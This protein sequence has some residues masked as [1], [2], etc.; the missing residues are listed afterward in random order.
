MCQ[1]AGKFTRHLATYAFAIA[2]RSAGRKP[3]EHTP[4]RQADFDSIASKEALAV[5]QVLYAQFCNPTQEK[6]ND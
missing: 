1:R 3:G 4:R 2:G 6:L 5:M